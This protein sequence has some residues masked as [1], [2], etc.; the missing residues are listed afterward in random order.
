MNLD[1][2]NV[3]R[4]CECTRLPNYT[5]MYTNMAAVTKFIAKNNKTVTS[6][7]KTM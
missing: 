3:L 1:S 6:A 5:I 2:V 4:M 7:S